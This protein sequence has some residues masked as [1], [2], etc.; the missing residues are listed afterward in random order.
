V[1]YHALT[2]ANLKDDA[3]NQESSNS[4]DCLWSAAADDWALV[5]EP[6]HRPLW[7]AMQLAAKVEKGTRLLD[8]GCGAGGACFLAAHNYGAEAYG[9]DASPEMIRLARQR[10]PGGH[11]EVADL[12][13]PPFGDAA[14]DVIHSSNALQFAASPEAAL[15]AWKQRLTASGRVVVGIWCPQD[16]NEQ[17]HI[18][19]AIRAILPQPPESASPFTLSP[20]GLLED[21]MKTAGLNVVEARDVPVT[22]EYPD[23]ETCWRGLRGGSQVQSAMRM[24]GPEAVYSAFIAAAQ[25]FLMTDGS[26]FIHNKMRYVLGQNF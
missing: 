12:A 14:F 8:A 13:A 7:M 6:Q 4:G 19:R 25:Q 22:F 2:L 5:Q 16:E 20:R 24:V 15:Q 10:L 9:F 18:M 3:V 23:M 26:V 11:F 21:V 1:I 17:I